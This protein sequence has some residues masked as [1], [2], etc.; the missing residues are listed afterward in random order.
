MPVTGRLLACAAVALAVAGCSGRLARDQRTGELL[1]VPPNEHPEIVALLRETPD[2]ERICFDCAVPD[3]APFVHAPDI[4][5]QAAQLATEFKFRH[6]LKTEKNP[7]KKPY[8]VD[9]R[10]RKLYEDAWERELK[11]VAEASDQIER[12]MARIAAHD[13]DSIRNAM[14]YLHHSSRLP[15]GYGDTTADNT[16][17]L[18]NKYLFDLPESA[19]PGSP[20]MRTFG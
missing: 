9:P 1:V 18:L 13:L 15:S 19:P 3:D 14:A 5:E 6:G 16:L 12:Q 4:R 20:A 7:F 11:Y 2:W 10:F 8:P 17:L